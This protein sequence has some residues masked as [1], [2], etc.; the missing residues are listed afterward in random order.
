MLDVALDR[1][2][3]SSGASGRVEIVRADESHAAPLLLLVVHAYAQEGESWS[4]KP[5]LNADEQVSLADVRA[6][7]AGSRGRLLVAMEGD[8]IVGCVLVTRLAGRRSMLGLLG[9]ESSRRRRGLGAR[10]ISAAEKAARDAFGSDYIEL[11]VLSERKPLI[12]YYQR[13]GFARTGEQRTIG[14]RPRAMTFSVMEKTL[15]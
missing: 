13:H 11:C 9:V 3:G 1:D 8:A 12:A 14:R 4:G 2:P 15:G 10:L 5:P 6:M 7:I